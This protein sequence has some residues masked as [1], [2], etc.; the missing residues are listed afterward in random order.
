MIDCGTHPRVQ[1]SADGGIPTRFSTID[2]STKP[3]LLVIDLVDN[4]S[5]H[6]VISMPVILGLK[7]DLDLNAEDLTVRQVLVADKV[8]LLV[9]AS[10]LHP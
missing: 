9:S 6:E 8:G 4:C 2:A 7:P 1:L 5:T 10:R 3:S